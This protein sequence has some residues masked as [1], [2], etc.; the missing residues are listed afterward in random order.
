MHGRRDRTPPRPVNGAGCGVPAGGGGRPLGCAVG[1][2]RG[3][4]DLHRFA[5]RLAQA[6]TLQAFIDGEEAQF[7]RDQIGDL[8]AARAPT[9]VVADGQ[10]GDQPTPLRLAERTQQVREPIGD[11]GRRIDCGERPS[12]PPKV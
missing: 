2:Q 3:L 12:R 7:Q 10:P 6:F 9:L 11:A 5:A 8:R 4:G 1:G